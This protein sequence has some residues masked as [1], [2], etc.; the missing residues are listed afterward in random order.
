MFKQGEPVFGNTGRSL[1][2]SGIEEVIIIPVGQDKDCLLV[3]QITITGGSVQNLRQLETVARLARMKGNHAE[4]L[5]FFRRGNIV[6]VF[7]DADRNV[8]GGHTYIYTIT[9]LAS[10]QISYVNWIY[11]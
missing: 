8:P 4:F 10:Y 2:P 3:N 1:S 6:T 9:I 5:V 7:V 11:N